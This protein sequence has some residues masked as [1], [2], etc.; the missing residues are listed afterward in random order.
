MNSNKLI[1]IAV[2]QQSIYSNQNFK[3]RIK[4][5]TNNMGIKNTKNSTG[6]INAIPNT[7]AGQYPEIPQPIPNRLAPKMSF[8]SIIELS[9]IKN[10]I[11]NKGLLSLKT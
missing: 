11:S 8:L 7:G 10:F 5:N 6:L 9:E 2:K 1:S 3:I 4:P